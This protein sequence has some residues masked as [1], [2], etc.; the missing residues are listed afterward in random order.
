MGAGLC[1]KS[2]FQLYRRKVEVS[3]GVDT[4][5]LWGFH[6]LVEL[7]LELLAFRIG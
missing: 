5:F 7:I 1:A 6:E 3:V 2:L 4:E